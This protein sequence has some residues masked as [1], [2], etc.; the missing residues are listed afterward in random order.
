[1]AKFY[2]KYTA[3]CS[4]EEA[5]DAVNDTEC[6]AQILPYCLDSG[7]ISESKHDKVAF[8]VL[9]AA[10]VN[11]RIVTKNTCLRPSEIRVSL[12]EGP[13][14]ELNGWWRFSESK[15]GVIIEVSFRY[16]FTSWWME[17]VFESVFSQMLEDVIQKFVQRAVS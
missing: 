5:Y 13:M 7:V 11:V 9:G 4:I 12:V 6:Y 16:C 17:Q 15:E 14:R 3:S 1:M 2:K 10:G 8:L